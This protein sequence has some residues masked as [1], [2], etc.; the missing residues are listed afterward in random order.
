MFESKD[1]PRTI[2]IAGLR[3]DVRFEGARKWLGERQ[4]RSI[5]YAGGVS[6]ISGAIVN[7]M[8]EAG[9][10]AAAARAAFPFD[11]R[12]VHAGSGTGAGRALHNGVRSA[13]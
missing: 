13:S 10:R 8:S 4:I 5:S 12:A 7:D 9:A 3:I 6:Q 1:H 11:L 2:M